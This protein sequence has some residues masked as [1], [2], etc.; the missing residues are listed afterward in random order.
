MKRFIAYSVGLLAIFMLAGCGQSDS[1]KDSGIKPTSSSQKARDVYSVKVDN[2]K[3]SDDDWV[4]SGTTKAPDDA[5]VLAVIP[6]NEEAYEERG[7]RN[8]AT[9]VDNND[10][11]AEIKDGKLKIAISALDTMSTEQEE[12]V[13]SKSSVY[14]AGVE[15]YSKSPDEDVSSKLAKRI[16]KKGTKQNLTITQSQ[17]QFIKDLDNDIDTENNDSESISSETSS[18]EYERVDLATFDRY[19][20]KYIDENVQIQ[21]TVMK[22]EKDDDNYILTVSDSEYDHQIAVGVSSDVMGDL[23]DA[24][25]EEDDTI[26][27]KGTSSDTYSSTS[28]SGSESDVPGINADSINIDSM[29]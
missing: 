6:E 2:V 16:N 28:I 10:Y 1:D 5:E 12:K 15:D 26:T 23:G 9:D 20:K 24:R 14:I 19:F 4:I 17:I 3:V 8:N 27:V 18:I 29:Q 13:G 25:L 21:G 11:F 22:I 7:D